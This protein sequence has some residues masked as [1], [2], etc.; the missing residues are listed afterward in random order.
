M[1]W[2]LAARKTSTV[3][4]AS[5]KVRTSNENKNFGNLVFT[6]QSLTA[7]ILLRRGYGDTSPFLSYTFLW[8]FLKSSH[9]SN[10]TVECEQM[11]GSA[12]SPFESGVTGTCNIKMRGSSLS[13]FEPGITGTCNVK[14]RGSSLSPFGSGVTGTC[15]IKMRGSSLSS[16]EPGV[17]GTCNIKMRG[18][19]LSPFESGRHWD[20]QYKA[21]LFLPLVFFD[22]SYFH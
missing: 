12:L 22:Y 19:S 6:I 2:S 13:P 16:F 18:S 8:G 21:A 3:F 7:S 4:I 1:T 14:M 15:N 11:R 17:T 20:L 9:P 10:N 5:D